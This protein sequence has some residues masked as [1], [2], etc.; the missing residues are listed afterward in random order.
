MKEHRRQLVHTPQD[1]G[2]TIFG[3]PEVFKFVLPVYFR[4][5]TF[6]KAFPAASQ[7][8]PKI[9]MAWTRFSDFIS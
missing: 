3:A 2:A 9:R 4:A 5:D 8:F 1:R 7:A 6:S